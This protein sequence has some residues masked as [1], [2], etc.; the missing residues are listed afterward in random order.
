VNK[1]GGSIPDKEYKFVYSSRSVLKNRKDGKF[2]DDVWGIIAKELEDKISEGYALYGE[3]V[4]YTPGGKTIQ[5]GYDYGVERFN[6]EFKVYRM[7][8][9]TSDG[10][11]RELEWYEIEE[12]CY[13]NGLQLVPVYY[14]GLARDLFADNIPMD[15]DWSENFL[16]KM[17]E[18]YL[19]KPCEFC[20]TGVIN[21]GVVLRIESSDTKIALKFKSPQFLVKESA[22][23]DNNEE[24]MEEES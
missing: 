7:T 8:H 11:C 1:C 21:E 24:D 12:F 20:N 14:N 9:T 16:S 2:T 23:R 6:C 4:G 13:G 19:D 5:S 3:I 10:I 17:K 15:N 22:A 18:K